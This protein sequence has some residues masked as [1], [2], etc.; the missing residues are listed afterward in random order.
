MQTGQ[1][2]VQTGTK[3][4]E[5]AYFEARLW[6]S[7]DSSLKQQATNYAARYFEKHHKAPS[8][9]EVSEAI[10]YRCQIRRIR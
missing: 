5:I 7:E 9:E 10:G 6:N 1:K 3:K 2:K 4:V 8:N